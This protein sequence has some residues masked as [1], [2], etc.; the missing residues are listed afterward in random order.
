MERE[1]LRNRIIPTVLE[2]TD[3]NQE[4]GNEEFNTIDYIYLESFK[5][6]KGGRRIN[7]ERV[8]SATDFTKMNNAFIT[9]DLSSDFNNFDN[10]NLLDEDFKDS[11]DEFDDGEFYFE[12]FL[13]AEIAN[14]FVLLRSNYYG[15]D[16]FRAEI[17][18]I[19]P[20]GAIETKTTD[21]RGAAICP[22]LRFKLPNENDNFE[23][24]IRAVTNEYGEI[25]YHT[26]QLG[27]YP[28]TKV[29]MALNNK[30]ENLYNK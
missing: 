21:F 30:L 23:C 25:K 16:S 4:F 2:N 28:K 27:E 26:V 1:D 11:F 29:K 13:D 14:T 5:D 3:E 15:E 6:Q 12:D 19:K 9:E 20:D 18:V 17:D 24:N 22:S 8:V 7:S 10:S